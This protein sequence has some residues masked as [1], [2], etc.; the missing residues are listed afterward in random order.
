MRSVVSTRPQWLG[1][2]R[3]L[4]ILALAAGMV[5]FASPAAAAPP[6]HSDHAFTGTVVLE[7]YCA[8]PITIT[9]AQTG[10]EARFFDE[11]GAVTRIVAHVVEQD[12]FT[13]NGKVLQ[14]LPFPVN[15][16]LRFDSQGNLTQYVANGLVTKVPLPDGSVFVSAGRVNW[17]NHLDAVFI[18][19]PDRGTPV[20]KDRFCAAL[21][22]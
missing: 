5:V 17:L 22:P 1:F 11:N 12:T 4:T 13:A 9:F 16:G 8:F 6:V 7:D 21:A 18:V 14:S 19:E 20:N 3:G 15:F 10:H 2:A